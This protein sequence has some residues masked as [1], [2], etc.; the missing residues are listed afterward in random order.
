MRQALLFAALLSAA[1]GLGAQSLAASAEVA[2]RSGSPEG[3]AFVR[4]NVTNEQNIALFRVFRG[5]TPEGPW[6]LIATVPGHGAGI[7]GPQAYSVA[8]RG[9]EVGR[10]LHYM[11]E[12]ENT[13]GLTFRVGPVS[14]TVLPEAS[15]E[16]TAQPASP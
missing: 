15:P 2:A 14:Y 1:P 11:I 7:H 8:D 9:L 12:H 16:A 5:E 10:R 13:E 4:W 6:V 3:V